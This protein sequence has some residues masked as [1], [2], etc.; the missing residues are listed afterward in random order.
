MYNAIELMCDFFGILLGSCLKPSP[1]PP[2]T[3]ACGEGTGAG[4]RD[5]RHGLCGGGGA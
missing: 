5:Q 3:A 1:P 2:T 4:L